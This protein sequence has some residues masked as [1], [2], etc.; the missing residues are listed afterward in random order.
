[1]FDGV[2]FKSGIFLK[3][4]AINKIV[5]K[6]K[7]KKREV[8]VVGDEV[9]DIEAARKSRIKIISVSWG[10]N[11]RRIILKNKPDYFIEK[12]KDILK[13]INHGSYEK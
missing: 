1:M 4:I 3:H 5:K 6:Y 8:V 10:Y 9:R 2:Y 12:P 11:N 7:L 13:I